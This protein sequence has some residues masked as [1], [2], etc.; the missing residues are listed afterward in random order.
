MCG[1]LFIISYINIR[2]IKDRE[3]YVTMQIR[4]I[5]YNSLPGKRV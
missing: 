5:F 2:T 1:N 4:V 3:F